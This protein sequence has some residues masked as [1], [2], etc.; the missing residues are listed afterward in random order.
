MSGQVNLTLKSELADPGV[1]SI[2][3]GTS[4]QVTRFG[5]P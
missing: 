3:M 2:L 1:Q 5:A 4:K